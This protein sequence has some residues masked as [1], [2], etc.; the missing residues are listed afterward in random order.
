MKSIKWPLLTVLFAMLGSPCLAAEEQIQDFTSEVTVNPDSTLDVTETI[1]VTAAGRIIKHGIYRDFPTH[2]QDK[3]GNNVTVGFD[4]KA[5]S[6]DGQPVPY[7]V[8]PES[9]GQR[10]YMGGTDT[11]ITH[12]THTFILHYITNRQLGFFPDHDALYWNV[13]G[14]GW[15]FPIERATA[16]ITL[17]PHATPIQKAAYT[18]PQGA[19]GK[20]FAFSQNADGR[21]VFITTRMLGSHEGLTVAASWQKGLVRE[22]TTLDRVMYILWDNP[23]VFIGT[24]SLALLLLYYLYFSWKVHATEPIRTVIPLFAPPTDIPLPA[25]GYIFHKGAPKKL[26]P[27]VIVNLA[28]KRHIIITQQKYLLNNRFTLQQQSG[29]APV[30]EM[31]QMAANT[32]FREGNPLPVDDSHY[33][34]LQEASTTLLLQLHN[35]FKDAYFRNNGSYILF[36]F[37]FSAI[38]AFTMF[39]TG[40]R[41]LTIIPII[42]I[43]VLFMLNLL[44]ISRMRSYTKSGK[45]LATQIEGFKMFLSVTEKDRFNKLTPP[46]ITPEIFEKYFPY[47]MILDVENAWGGKFSSALAQAGQNIHDYHP[48]WYP[49]YNS[50]EGINQLSTFSSEFTST[51]SSAS[52][53]PGSSDGSDGSGNS[54]GGGGGGGGGGY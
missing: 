36:G 19:K 4:V 13:T 51:I 3:A 6:R 32:L 21:L 45:E 33:Q 18:G 15:M 24:A 43:A 12:G 50:N 48:Y 17:P 40:G 1:I 20:N 7:S 54:G 39:M 28:I 53:P 8:K 30:A 23:P 41:T 44:F 22:P 46:D 10:V 31:E 2:Y 16:I 14:N 49:D 34:V 38:A 47:A 11:L 27:S 35:D 25:I 5:V 29:G 26:L 52:V 37:L 42:I 9:N